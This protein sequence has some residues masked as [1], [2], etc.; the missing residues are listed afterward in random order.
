MPAAGI[1][2]PKS[3]FSKL[4]SARLR[5]TGAFQRSARVHRLSVLIKTNV[6]C[7]YIE[8]TEIKAGV[9]P[10]ADRGRSYR[11]EQRGRDPSARNRARR[12]TKVAPGLSLRL[13]NHR[14]GECGSLLRAHRGL[15]E[16]GQLALSRDRRALGTT[17]VS[18][19]HDRRRAP[20]QAPGSGRHQRSGVQP[21]FPQRQIAQPPVT[22]Y[23]I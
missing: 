14:L 15:A 2:S 19:L 11:P 1:S 4:G 10:N 13:F 7:Q 5:I 22:P 17:S 18:L 12:Y 6:H 21:D 3:K 23:R 9:Q 16:G 8:K 20:A